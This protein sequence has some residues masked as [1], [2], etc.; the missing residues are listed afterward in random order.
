MSKAILL[1]LSVLLGSLAWADDFHDNMEKAGKAVGTLR[2]AL[3]AKSMSDVTAAAAV[4]A[5]VLPKTVAKWEELKRPDAVTMAKEIAD[6]AKELKMAADAGHAEH[7][8]EVFGKMGGKCKGCHDV[9][10]EKL[11]DGKYKIKGI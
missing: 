11:P 2:K 1:T 5:E 4:L 6:L 3:P 9:H 10:R 7:V 8:Q